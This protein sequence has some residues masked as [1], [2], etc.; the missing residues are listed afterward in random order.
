[1]RSGEREAGFFDDELLPLEEI[2]KRHLL[3][4]LERVEGNK[5]RAAEILGISRATV[6]QMLA[7]M[8]L[9]TA[10]EGAVQ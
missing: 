10:P 2:Q 8:K 3:R 9:D 6:Y 7:K 1:L 4:I 5:V